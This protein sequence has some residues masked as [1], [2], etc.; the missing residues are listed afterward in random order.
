MIW[1][2][3]AAIVVALG[4]VVNGFVAIKKENP[5]FY[6]VY[7]ALCVTNIAAPLALMKLIVLN[8]DIGVV[9]GELGATATATSPSEEDDDATTLIAV[10]NA[11][12]CAF[13][14]SNFI[15]FY[16]GFSK[17]YELKTHL[18]RTANANKSNK[19]RNAD[20]SAS[21]DGDAAVRPKEEVE[22]RTK[23]ATLEP[24]VNP[25]LDAL[26]LQNEQQSQLLSTMCL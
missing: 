16:N 6:Y 1:S 2:N 4:N 3:V 10:V 9:G 25:E 23:D 26:N 24:D 13:F 19:D 15:C 7:M 22:M 14:G 21:A 8:N 20:K 5:V 11:F 18:F 17:Q 12:A